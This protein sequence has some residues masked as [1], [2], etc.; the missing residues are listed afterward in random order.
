MD[1]NNNNQS[2]VF[3]TIPCSDGK[4]AQMHIEKVRK[5]IPIIFL[6]GVMGS[7]LKVKAEAG[8][9]QNT[10][11]IWCLDSSLSMANWLL[12]GAKARKIKLDPEKTEVDYRGIVTDA[13]EDEISDIKN[14]Y[15]SVINEYTKDVVIHNR[16]LVDKFKDGALNKDQK[17]EQAKNNHPE[18]QLFDNRRKRGWGSVG[19]MS[20]GKFLETLQSYLF[21]PN[22]QLSS[23]LTS[24]D[25]KLPFVLEKGSKTQL[26]FTKNEIEICKNYDFPV[27]AMGYNWLK[28]NAESAEQ[29]KTLVEETIPKFYKKRGKVCDKVIL[30]T[31]SMGGLVARYYTE[32]LGGR[33]KVYGVINGVQPSTGAAA[34][35]TRMKRGNEA[36]WIMSNVLGKDAAEMTAVCAQAPGPLQLLPSGEYR[37]KCSTSEEYVPEWLTITTPDGK[38]QSF[39]Q[40]NPYDDIYTNKGQWW[41]VCE[42]HLINPLNTKYDL[43]TMQTDWIKYE[44]LIDKIVKPFHEKIA[45][46]YHPNTYVFFGIEE[47][48]NTIRE[49]LLTYERVHWQSKIIEYSS[50]LAQWPPENYIGDNNRLDLKELNEERT[51]KTNATEKKR[52]IKIKYT[53]KKADSNGDGTV[54]KSSG[55]IPIAKIQARMHIPVGHAPAYDNVISQE[56]ILRAIVDIIQKVSKN[57][58]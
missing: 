40:T 13:A 27:Y 51:L 38:S 46:K 52:R 21:Q 19:Y 9:N 17:I 54:P 48:G 33:E 31:H 35:Y 1:Q 11:K 32:V 10:K 14:N 57:E 44:L 5:V 23:K 36:G 24:L 53:L 6:P 43:T 7:N 28:S 56:F 30:I 50:I 49:E 41:C 18:N 3:N 15:T 16:D 12:M 25:K 34:A 39:P 37:A 26:T 2:A 42:P 22:R 4:M 20:Y 58:Q 47:S 8:K 55:E 29:L 45:G